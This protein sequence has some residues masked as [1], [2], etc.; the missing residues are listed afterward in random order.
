M[1]AV[2]KA[3]AQEHVRDRRAHPVDGDQVDRVEL[4]QVEGAVVVS[5]REVGL[6]AIVEVADV[7]H[8]DR[9]RRSWRTGCARPRAASRGRSTARWLPSARAAARKAPGSRR[10]RASA[11]GA[12]RTRPVM[13]GTPRQT[14]RPGRCAGSRFRGRSSTGPAHPSRPFRASIIASNP[15]PVSRNDLFRNRCHSGTCVASRR[16]ATWPVRR[17]R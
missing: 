17:G 2:G 4:A 6:G 10:T 9:R 14:P 8:R 16:E 11:S 3:E 7:V 12:G 1:V 5:G 15:R 13:P